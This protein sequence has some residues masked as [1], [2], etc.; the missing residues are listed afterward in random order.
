MRAG[1]SIGGFGYG[2]AGDQPV[3]G[4][5]DGLSGDTVGVYR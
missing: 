1:P 3:T 4:N 5:W 2:N